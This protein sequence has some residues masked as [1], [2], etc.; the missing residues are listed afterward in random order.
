MVPRQV[1]GKGGAGSM[2]VFFLCIVQVK[3][4]KNMITFGKEDAI[5]LISINRGFYECT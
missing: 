5:L 1:E 3:I 4:M 2:K